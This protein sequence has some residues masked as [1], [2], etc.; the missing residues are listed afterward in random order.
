MVPSGPILRIYGN[1]HDLLDHSERDPLTGLLNRQTFNSA[2]M[3]QRVRSGFEDA[4]MENGRRTD[5]VDA[6]AW[7]GVADIDHFK[8]VND[9]FGHPI[10]AE[11]L[12]LLLAC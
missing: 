12:L 7:L 5:H 9:T 1:F 11:V 10:D 8:R 2:L 3:G 6:G 4:Q